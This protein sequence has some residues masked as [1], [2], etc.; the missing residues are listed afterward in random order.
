MEKIVRWKNVRNEVWNWR[1]K[2]GNREENE[3]VEGRR[4][5]GEKERIGRNGEK[6]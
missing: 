4:W 6:I 2:N 1:W 5:R 3:N